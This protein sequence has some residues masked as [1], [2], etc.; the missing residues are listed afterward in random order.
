MFG[1]LTKALGPTEWK[2]A[3]VGIACATS[4]V[5]FA[6]YMI[7]RSDDAPGLSVSEHFMI[8]AR[9]STTRREPF[10]NF[11]PPT[12]VA[13]APVEVDTMPIGSIGPRPQ[14]PARDTA[15]APVVKELA[16]FAVRGAFDGKILVQGPTG[17]ELV[18]PGDKV[19]DAGPVLS[20][21]YDKGRW[22]VLTEA[23]TISSAAPN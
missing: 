5:I 17:F 12:E 4:S 13:S 15:A 20:I 18:G 9:P 3:S 2:I 8:F 23:G 10:M 6:A 7:S 16:G 21:K 22:I 1:W 11:T 14:T 19:T